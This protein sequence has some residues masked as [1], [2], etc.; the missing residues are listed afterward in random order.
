MDKQ[1]YFLL[2]PGII[3]GVAIVDLLKVFS[4][5]KNYYEMVGWGVMYLFAIITLWLDLYPLLPKLVDSNVSFV[6]IIAQAVLYARGANI[7]TPE[8]SDEDTEL[9]F[10]KHKKYFFLI[11]AGIVFSN[12]VLQLTIQ[13][14]S[15]PVWYRLI[16]LTVTFALAFWDK[17]WFRNII[18]VIIFSLMFIR[19]FITGSP[20]MS[21]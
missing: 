16:W 18:L 8:K 15:I 11:I 10:M 14:D 7:L 5:R 4:H 12:M 17:V 20:L 6:L 9:Y 13:K 19:L 21:S 2:I 3:Y 1:E